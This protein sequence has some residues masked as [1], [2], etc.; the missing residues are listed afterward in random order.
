MDM[1]KLSPPETSVKKQY[2]LSG[3][4]ILITG[5]AGFLG[6]HFAEAVAEMGGFPILLDMHPDSI[7]EGLRQLKQEGIKADG[8]ALDITNSE[9]VV[10]TVQEV[11]AKYPSIDVLINSAAFAMKNLQAE[12]DGFFAP[13]EDYELR[14]VAGQ[15]GCEFDREPL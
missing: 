11:D 14:F 4:Q 12:G 2:D 8:F 13:F 10:Q 6:L 5:G 9:Q 7:G 3:K 1:S 15:S